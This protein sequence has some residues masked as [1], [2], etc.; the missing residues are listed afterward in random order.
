MPRR[1]LPFS[2]FYRSEKT[3]Q[4]IAQIVDSLS[5]NG[6]QRTGYPYVKKTTFFMMISCTIYKISLKIFLHLNV[7]NYK[8]EV[9]VVAQL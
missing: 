9:P 5:T 3:I 1:E 4:Q 6:D 7:K 2:D 8:T